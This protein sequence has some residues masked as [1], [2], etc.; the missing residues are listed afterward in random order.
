VVGRIT[1]PSE[2][3]TFTLNYGFGNSITLSTKVTFDFQSAIQRA[4]MDM[5]EKYWAQTKM[6]L[7]SLFLF[8]SERFFLLVVV[9]SQ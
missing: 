6:S 3:M 1:E 7:I 4:G 5:V 8:S 9:V 2:K